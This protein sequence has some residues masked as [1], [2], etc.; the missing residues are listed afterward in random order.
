MSLL[1]IFSYLKNKKEKRN[2]SEVLEAMYD[3]IQNDLDQDKGS[4]NNM[5]LDDM[6]AKIT[7]SELADLRVKIANLEKENTELVRSRTL[8]I[9]AKSNYLEGFKDGVSFVLNKGNDLPPF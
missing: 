8:I 9:E 5:D 6:D 7:V 3:K 1:Q 2:L 4:V